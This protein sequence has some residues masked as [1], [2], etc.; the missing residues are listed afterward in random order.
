MHID[1]LLSQ[2]Q[3][4]AAESLPMTLS[5]DWAQGRTAFGGVS[6]ALLYTAMQSKVL[7][8]RALR[9]LTT[10][11]VGPLVADTPFRFEVELLREG[12]SASQVVARSLQNDQVV[13][14]Q[15]GCFGGERGSALVVENHD[16][17]AMPA[18][19][20]CELFPMVNG[21]TPSFIQH[22]DLALVAG[23][24][25]YTGSSDSHTHGWMRFKQPPKQISDAHLICLIDAWP[26]AVIQ[27]MKRP[28]PAST[29]SWN[30]EFIHPHQ[31]VAPDD[32][33]AYQAHTRQS[34]AGYA[35]T[36][37]NI[38]DAAGELVAIS[39]QSVAVFE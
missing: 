13:V 18:A 15:Q 1:T 7:P 19:E 31:P 12:K 38:W 10:N 3:Q 4:I 35:H 25:P 28:S 9:S 17:H 16:S 21:V 36:E 6:A 33:F 27:M 34:A 24:L 5:P 26:P 22:M 8:G 11:F 29:M 39:R 23:Q 37:A 32:W 14:I 30:L 2:A 20:Q